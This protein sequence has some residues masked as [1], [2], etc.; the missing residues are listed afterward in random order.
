M[1]N[2]FNKA[3]T[4]D[5]FFN[6]SKEIL[7]KS[8][9]SNKYSSVANGLDYLIYDSNETVEHLPFVVDKSSVNVCPD[10]YKQLNRIVG[11]DTNFA[12][13]CEMAAPK[14]KEILDLIKKNASEDFIKNNNN[15][16]GNSVSVWIFRI[17]FPFNTSNAS[18]YIEFN[19]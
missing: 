16:R 11:K 15:L 6:L 2:L 9:N 14:Q 8:L 7:T 18:F 17:P 10:F 1:Y 19:V 12:Y 4:A 3:T 5:E 13:L